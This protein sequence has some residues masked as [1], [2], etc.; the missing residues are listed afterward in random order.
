[1]NHVLQ[2]TQLRELADLVVQSENWCT[3]AD[4]SEQGYGLF[5]SFVYDDLDEIVPKLSLER[6]L[7]FLT[8]LGITKHTRRG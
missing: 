7:Q 4:E 6:S 5:A 3:S 8:M 1:M 2:D